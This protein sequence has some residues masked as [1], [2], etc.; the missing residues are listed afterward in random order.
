MDGF[1]KISRFFGW[2]FLPILL[3]LFGGSCAKPT[4]TPESPTAHEASSVKKTSSTPTQPISHS[5]TVPGDLDQF[6]VPTGDTPPPPPKGFASKKEVMAAIA[7]QQ[8]KL[9]NQQG[10]DPNSVGVTFLQDVEYGKVGDRPLLLDLY[11]PKTLTKPTPG[12]IFLHGG[13][14][15][16]GNKDEYH[17]YC[18]RYAARGYVVATISYRFAQEALFPA[19]VQD[20]K[21]AVRWMRANAAKYNVNPDQIVILGGSAGGYLALM[22]GYTAGLP[23]FEG[24]GGNSGVSS[25]VQAVVNFYGPSDMTTPFAQ[26]APQAKSLL[27][28]TYAEDPE[29][30]KKASPLTYLKSGCPPTLIFHGSIDDTVPVEQSDALAVKLKEV[31][32]PYTYERFEGWPHTMDMALDVNIRCQWF[33][34]RFMKQTF[35]DT[36]SV[37]S[38]IK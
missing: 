28:K 18:V 16:N 38:A 4:A 15:T 12:M 37:S 14:W 19:Q 11:I 33:L 31:G 17:C 29:L 36:G 22:A 3:F 20:A 27:G 24:D 7:I 32:V 5:A 30:Y 25:A 1:A 34:T 35:A 8:V 2:V 9:I 26:N 23:E 13:G 6:G 21:C 10:P